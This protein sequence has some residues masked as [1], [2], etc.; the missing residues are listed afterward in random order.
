MNH[1]GG[2]RDIRLTSPGDIASWTTVD[3]TYA[4]EWQQTSGM[5]AGVSTSLGVTNVLDR[6]P[7]FVMNDNWPIY[8]DGT[9]ANPLGRF[10]SLVLQ[11]KW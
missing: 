6:A 10:A 1:T 9:N 3:V 4:R 11:K 8:F 5:W 7:P 2:Y